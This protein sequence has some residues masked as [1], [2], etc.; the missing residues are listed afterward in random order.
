MLPGHEL[1][2]ADHRHQRVVDLMRGAASKRAERLEPLGM[3]ERCNSEGNAT[4]V[5]PCYLLACTQNAGT[6]GR[7]RRRAM[8]NENMQLSAE[9]YVAL[10]QREGARYQYYNDIAGN[11]TW[12]IGTLAH[13][14]PCTPEELQRRV[15]AEEVNAQLAVRV[16]AAEISVRNGVSHNPLTQAQFDSLVSFVY[17]VGTAGARAVLQAADQQPAAAVGNQMRDYIFIH[18]RDAQGHRLPPVRVQALVNRRNEEAAPFDN[19]AGAR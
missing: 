6:S 2:E 15:T 18:P 3:M 17:N 8:A 14:G 13:D 11:C 1:G 16:H 7:R 5:Q 12:G 9:G 10:R 19:N 4:S